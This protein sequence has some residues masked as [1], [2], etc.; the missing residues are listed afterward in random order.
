MEWFYADERDEQ[1]AI[2]ES[3]LPSLVANGVIGRETLVWHEGLADWVECARLR[4]DLFQSAPAPAPEVGAEATEN[5]AQPEDAALE[6]APPLPPQ[7]PAAGSMDSADG[8]AVGS[9]ILGIAGLAGCLCAG[10]FAIPFSIGAV[11]LGHISK[12]KLSAAGRT[13]KIGLAQAGLITG[14]IGLI[15]EVLFLVGMIA[16]FVFSWTTMPSVDPVNG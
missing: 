3:D 5:G 15:L 8:M 4:P 6:K 9:L 16:M 14:Y 7:I 13:E 10:V 1:I 2:D 11:V 12:K